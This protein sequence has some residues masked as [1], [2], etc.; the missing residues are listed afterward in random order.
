[1]TH[2]EEQLLANLQQALYEA[3]QRELRHSIENIISID[4]YN[5]RSIVKMIKKNDIKMF[6]GTQYKL[7]LDQIDISEQFRDALITLLEQIKEE[8]PSP[9]SNIQ[10]N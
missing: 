1:M 5:L 2:Q 9:Q 3:N 6:P 8:E 10:I 4:Y 7:I